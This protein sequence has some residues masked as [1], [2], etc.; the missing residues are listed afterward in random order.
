MT[1]KMM[2]GGGGVLIAAYVVYATFF[3]ERVPIGGLCK[4]SAMCGGE[5]LGFGGFGANEKGEVCTKK[6]D[7]PSD[8]PAPTTCQ[9]IKIDSLSMK[10]G[11]MS[12]QSARY[13]LNP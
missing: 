7:G 6:C 2:L 8:C 3:L 10:D 11:K 1:K 9:D 13:C 4:D 12:A 5:C